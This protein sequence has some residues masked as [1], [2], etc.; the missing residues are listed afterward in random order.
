MTADVECD[1]V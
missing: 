1:A